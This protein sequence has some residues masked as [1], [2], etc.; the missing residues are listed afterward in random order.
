MPFLSPA[1]LTFDLQTRPTTR[2]QTR[3]ARVNLSQISSAIPEI[4]QKLHF[5]SVVTL[6]FDIQ[7]RLSEGPNTS[8]LQIRRKS[9]QR[10]PGY[11]THKQKSHRQH[12]KQNL[13]QFTVCGKNDNS[14]SC[15]RILAWM[16]KYVHLKKN[17][18][19]TDCKSAD[20]M[21]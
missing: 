15:N 7:T 1:T 6:T 14:L 8:S 18:M 2:D 16:S 10:F 4:C 9:V 19:T 20:L 12:Q 5:L 11:F 17:L 3:L 13:T 21:P